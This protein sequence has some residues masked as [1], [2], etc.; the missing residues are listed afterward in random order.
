MPFDWD[1]NYAFNVAMNIGANPHFVMT[2]ASP[3][4]TRKDWSVIRDNSLEDIFGILAAPSMGSGG[5]WSYFRELK[6]CVGRD[7]I[8]VGHG[9]AE[10][11][12]I[13]RLLCWKLNILNWFFDSN[14]SHPSQMTQRSKSPQSFERNQQ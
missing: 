1:Q 13:F 3:W 4:I 10:I 5:I 9:N 2:N 11:Y 14:L 12:G 6:K 8:W 7:A